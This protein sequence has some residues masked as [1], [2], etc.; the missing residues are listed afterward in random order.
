[1]QILP[2]FTSR[3]QTLWN[4]A[5]NNRP[6]DENTSSFLD[7]LNSSLK[8]VEESAGE[9]A[10]L[11]DTAK[12]VKSAHSTSAAT[13]TTARAAVQVQSPYSRNTSNGVTYTLDEVCFTK[14]EVKE[15]YNDL[16]KAGA[17]PDS[18]S[19]LA[20]LAEMPDGATLAQVTA[21]VKGG[22]GTP[23]LTDEDK[24]NIT[25]LLKKVDPSGVL[26]TNVQT[27]MMQGNAQQAFNTISAFVNKLDPAGT[28]EVTQDE[29][30]SLGRG[31][32]LGTSNLQTLVNSFGGNASITCLNE[33]FGTLMA[34]V[35][36]FFTSQVAAQKTLDTALKTTLQ[37]RISKAR[38]RTEKEKQA[39]SLRDRTAQQSKVLIDKTVQQKTNNILGATLE[40]GHQTE[41]GDVKVA[42]QS[43]MIGKDD[44]A[45]SRQAHTTTDNKSTAAQRAPQAEKI[46]EPKASPQ[47]PVQQAAQQ[48]SQQSSQ[49]AQQSS[50]PAQQAS[51]PQQAPLPAQQQAK[52]DATNQAHAQAASQQAAAFDD[53]GQK[54]A[55]SNSGSDA[56]K[57]QKDKSSWGELLGKVDVK[58][59][60]ATGHGNAAAYAAAQAAQNTQGV[61]NVSADVLDVATVAPIG[62]QVA[63]QVEQGMLST[64]KGG[65][66]RL[67]LQL[68]PQ[69]LGTINVTLSVRNGE[70]SAI[71]RS[72][73][74]ETADMINR[75]V[76]AIRIN[77]EQ[78]GLKVDKV[79]VRQ[80]TPQEQNNTTWQD[81]NQHNTRQEEDARREE[82]ARLKNLASVRN[83]SINRE[84]STLEQ[85][86]HS[87]GNTARYATSNLSVVA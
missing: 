54:Y 32:G 10:D 4:A 59:A 37:P 35:T 69:E 81:F 41:T 82:L 86:V 77:L 12:P 49:T 79:E 61:Q 9:A 26:D 83:S 46:A 68:N 16:L 65:G 38:A 17:S 67:D 44:N 85:P 58:S 78:Q 45:N 76:D 52:P 31:L 47:T 1:M 8:G 48:S 73:K 7:V 40:A 56:D 42:A 51:Q 5:S 57:D 43:E 74:S 36:D 39:S 64:I 11:F 72:E 21:S 70:V 33:Q 50:Q 84:I 63:Q 55:D 19:K 23:V 29:A 71:I 87:L 22:N 30:I 15:L 6:D 66:T 13:A 34:P 80:E 25:S 53:K 75:Q 60:T 24:T 20:G 3:S 18:L 27:M 62:R 28:I 14:Q 2:T